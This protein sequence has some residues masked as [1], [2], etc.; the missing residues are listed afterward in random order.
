MEKEDQKTD[1]A[2]KVRLEYGN[3]PSTVEKTAEP[4]IEEIQ[5]KIAET[6]RTAA[7]E[8][9]AMTPAASVFALVPK[10]RQETITALLD[11]MAA[12]ERYA[13]IK[14]LTTDSG[15]VFFFSTT[16]IQ[17]DE[18]VAKSR[19]EE[20]KVKI[21]EK[22]RADSQDRVKLTPAGDL[23][24]LIPETERYRIAA[25]LKEMQENP[26]TADIKMVTASNGHVFFYS[27]WHMSNY[28]ALVLSRVTVKDPCATIAAMVR[29]E[30]R[31]YP[32]PTCVQFF[33]E[34]LFEIP[35]CDLKAIVDETL[36]K[37]EYGDIKML[38]HP[39]TGGVYLYS[40]RYLKDHMAA[41][42]M[43]W[44]EVGREANP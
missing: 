32:R 28:Y 39:T 9:S 34:D 20:A 26:A 13:D 36:K 7:G 29:D 8:H 24:E 10:S 42:L 43:D 1:A 18:A 3:E 30:S 38:V 23:Q 40:N 2:E 17:A 19:I 4:T 22:V 27:D 25:I 41:V 5:A 21:A 33:M 37:P 14:A 35:P 11:E 12:D 16:Y 44:Q 15:K 6:V 31:V